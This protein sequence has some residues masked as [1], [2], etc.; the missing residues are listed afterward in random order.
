MNKYNILF[1]D[2][3]K[4]ILDFYK[5]SLFEENEVLNERIYKKFFS[6]SL[7]LDMGSFE[8][9]KNIVE[10]CNKYEETIDVAVLDINFKEIEGLE[11][12]DDF[13]IDNKISDD[14]KFEDLGVKIAIYLRKKYPNISIIFVSGNPSHVKKT[15]KLYHSNFSFV[16]KVI[17]LKTE[18]EK[19][20][21]SVISKKQPKNQLIDTSNYLYNI[22]FIN[23]A[24]NGNKFNISIKNPKI[25]ND[26]NNDFGLE[27]TLNKK[28]FFILANLAIL[29]CYDDK[30]A[31]IESRPKGIKSNILEKELSSTTQKPESL[32]ESNQDF[33]K[34]IFKKFSYIDEPACAFDIG[35]AKRFEYGEKS[36]SRT[37][38]RNA[39]NQ[40][41]IKTC[42]SFLKPHNICP[43]K[44]AVF[45]DEKPKKIPI[46]KSI[47]F[48]RD[49][50]REEFELKLKTI[51]IEKY[52]WLDGSNLSTSCTCKSDNLYSIKNCKYPFCTYSIIFSEKSITGEAYTQYRFCAKPQGNF[53]ENI[54]RIIEEQI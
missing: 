30:K 6:R 9:V 10:N 28:P 37:K 44:L 14:F 48:L 42:I 39:F 51:D 35:K 45:Y 15:Y 26:Q 34:E 33:L 24:G 50:L 49:N 8:S 31:Q 3:Q 29:S 47:N 25:I 53:I 52:K 7:N 4:S 16:E 5:K 40:N 23:E 12:L 32:W 2:D 54:K 43:M 21:I 36:D 20:I 38:D 13:D 17:E 22:D 11:N 46:T 18:L 41:C 19:E 1:C 27:I